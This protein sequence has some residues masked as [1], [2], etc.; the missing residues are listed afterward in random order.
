MSFP[1]IT[2]GLLATM[3]YW[4]IASQAFNSYKIHPISKWLIVVATLLLNLALVIV[5]QTI[6]GNYGNA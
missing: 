3:P 1:N 6:G 2:T 5:N 4:S